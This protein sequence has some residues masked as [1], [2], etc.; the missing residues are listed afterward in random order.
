MKQ[1]KRTIFWK[2]RVSGKNS[3]G[4]RAGDASFLDGVWMSRRR[5]V[6]KQFPQAGSP[7]PRP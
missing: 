4:R 6:G 2:K 5:M 7:S 1:Q 3:E